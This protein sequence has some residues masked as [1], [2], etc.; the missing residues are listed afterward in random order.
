[1]PS[2][3]KTTKP[4]KPT[5]LTD[6][7]T[8]LITSICGS[9]DHADILSLRHSSRLLTVS[10]ADAFE[11]APLD[12]IT[13]T[14]SAAGLERLERLLTLPDKAKK[15]KHVTLH[16]LTPWG[17]KE[18]AGTFEN[19]EENP[20]LL[21][22]AKVR[23]ALINGLNAL[24]NLESIT[25]TNG[26]FKGI[27]E[28]PSPLQDE[29]RFD[30][31]CEV[32]RKTQGDR[33]SPRIYAFESALSLLPSLTNKPSLHLTI[34]YANLV[35]ELTA[36]GRAS[37]RPFIGCSIY[38]ILTPNF[39]TMRMR[40]YPVPI[41]CE[42][43]VWPC[44]VPVLEQMFGIHDFEADKVIKEYLRHLTLRGPARQFNVV[45]MLEQLSGRHTVVKLLSLT[46][47]ESDIQSSGFNIMILGFPYLTS[48]RLTD[49]V[50]DY[51]LEEYFMAQPAIESIFLI[52]CQG[53]VYHWEL[54][55]TGNPE[56]PLR[57]LIIED[58]I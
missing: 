53:P 39:T 40:T 47:E 16:V 38:N 46:I 37:P 36:Y 7:P 28:P 21:A 54:L 13:V 6:L 56:Y 10:S 34:D 35:S 2:P 41:G 3:S 52:R 30:P 4:T 45:E 31:I 23:T 57:E 51:Q 8:E 1:M 26:K 25:I 44:M 5:M 55:G 27:T 29:P 22:Y 20:Y 33:L 50:F 24:P 18:L 12:S 17:L 19:G 11:N 48:F 43:A 49:A 58:C 32:D 42:N 14:S 15:I 9:F